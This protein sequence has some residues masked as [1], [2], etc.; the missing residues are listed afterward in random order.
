MLKPIR[1]AI[2][3]LLLTCLP[4]TIC[5]S[6]T[7]ASVE[8]KAAAD[9]AEQPAIIE[10]LSISARFENDGNS[11][12]TV[13]KRI[14]IQNEA[15][16]RLYG[17][18]TFNF[19]AGQEFSIDT[20]EVHKKDGSI[21]KA[22]TANTQ[23]VTPEISRVAPMY[24]DIRQKQI[25]VPGLS[26][27]DEVI[28]QYTEKQ[29]ALIPNQFW[30]QYSFAKDFVVLSETVHLDIPKDRKVHLNFGP[31][32]K[33]EIKT[34]G[35]RIVYEW[36]AANQKVPEEQKTALIKERMTGTAPSDSIEL[37]TF[38]SWEQ[39]G[40]WYYDLQRERAAPTAAIR[41][42]A[43]ELTKGLDTQEAK[44]K[45]LYG[46]V[47][48]NFRYI[49]LD[50]GIGRYQPHPAEEVLGNKYGDC[51]DKH[52][53]LAALLEAAGIP[54]YPALINLGKSINLEVPSP[55]QFD[56]VITAVPMGKNTLFLDTTAEV[57]P[58]GM[59]ISPLRNKKALFSAGDATS[60]LVE[61]P[62]AL[63]FTAQEIFDLQGKID[64]SGTLEADVNYY[65]RGDAEIIFKTAFRQASPS[66]YKDIVQG[67]SYYGGFGGEVS[68]IKI[69]GLESLDQ[70]VRILYHYHRQEYL[71]LQDQSP[72]NSLPL[73]FTHMPKWEEKEDAL[74]LYPSTGEIIHKCR[75]ELPSG[76][77]VQTP[78]DVKLDREYAHY[79][80]TYSAQKN[81]VTAERK[82]IVVHEEISGDHRSDY[83][84]FQKAVDSDESQ[85]MVVRL[86]QGFVAAKVVS[87][88]ADVDELMRQAEIEYRERDY[89][90]AYTDF[91]KVAET[92]P[93]RK[94]IWT[95]VGLAE[96][97][98]GRY[99]EAISDYQ[100]AIAADSFDAQA[101]TEL[102][103]MYFTVNKSQDSMATGELKKALEIDPLNHR[104][105][106]LLGW[107]YSVVLHDSANAVPEL[108]KALAT[109]GDQVSDETQIRQMLTEAYFKLKQFDKGV[110]SV[111]RS[112]EAAPN[113]ATWN[114]AAYILAQD[115]QAL[116]LARQYADSALKELYERINKLEP[117]S[118]R[119]PDF[120]FIAQLAMTWDT[121]GWI[122]FK[123]GHTDRALKY[124]RAAWI[125]SQNREAAEH[126]GEIYEKLKNVPEATR[127]YAMS[128]DP[129]YMGHTPTPDKGRAR[130]VKLL[131]RQRAEQL[132]QNKMGEP[133]QM[134]T[135]H[136]GNIAPAGTKG[137]FYFVFA[138]D[139][140][141]IT[142]QVNSGDTRLQ[143]QL[144]KQE[145]KI[146]ATVVFPEGA[147]Q[148]LVRE[149][150][151]MCSS[152]SHSCDLVFT[153]SEM[154]KQ[155]YF[156]GTSQQ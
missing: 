101:H 17:I 138:S 27:G 85:N 28:F 151:V 154:P 103:G 26:V 111:K 8:K 115:D 116:D 40:K 56:H 3:L 141:K 128:A 66:K 77:S 148:K 81:V 62:A 22:G 48:L 73:S 93:K 107:E 37:S 1:W 135:I 65:I 131:G 54:A 52:T 100:K 57:A 13:R 87:A 50:F 14:K 60:H 155:I 70:G 110:E 150:F 152:Y 113:P 147:P 139:T 10:E 112:V 121:M 124:V 5:S 71:N 123:D 126:L 80:T 4:L 20:M 7:S 84:A 125:L 43:L 78:L 137:S 6:Q 51:K 99:E 68:Q 129:G 35:D 102:A 59:L 82:I 96:G 140:K 16:I 94:G 45:A 36:H 117:G 132:I 122:D 12:Q 109:E 146:A 2:C 64:G 145:A 142:I 44:I 127:F 63:P 90:G 89:N 114:N 79:Q 76:F 30:F 72:K 106:Y 69:E 34:T 33:P 104:A 41:A 143:D 49:G 9:A 86:P 29:S 38:E 18:I 58:Y 144:Q 42:K 39:V 92:D 11:V 119:L 88:P 47:S 25:T 19:I 67:L 149:G 133:S 156:Q 32:D 21:V 15:G 74:R 23:E 46:F 136:L 108:E 53:L 95:Q 105:H 153:N 97:H 24:S 83:A 61:T 130:L 91:R 75:I 134:R 120:I 118:I 98:L 31:E 55:G